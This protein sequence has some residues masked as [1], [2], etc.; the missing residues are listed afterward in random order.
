MSIPSPP[1]LLRLLL[2]EH[3]LHEGIR[4]RIY[5]VGAQ[6]RICLHV[7]RPGTRRRQVWKPRVVY[8][9]RLRGLH[10]ELRRQEWAFWVLCSHI[11]TRSCDVAW[12]AG[13][14]TSHQSCSPT[15]RTHFAS[16][17]RISTHQNIVVGPSDNKLHPTGHFR[18]HPGLFPMLGNLGGLRL[19]GLCAL[20][21]RGGDVAVYT[22]RGPDP[23]D[24][25]GIR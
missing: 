9:R 21:V 7:A 10:R 11:N 4:R 20:F 18:G 22:A 3:V 6:P 8:D 25:D 16:A 2:E 23:Y 24:R 14:H 17:I 12:Y 1:G 13:V 5:H 15:L 19:H